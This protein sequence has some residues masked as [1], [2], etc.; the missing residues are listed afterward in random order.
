MAI[1]LKKRIIAA[2]LIPV[3]VL[4]ITLC[5]VKQTKAV[6]GAVIGAVGVL[7]DVIIGVEQSDTYAQWYEN[8]YRPK[9]NEMLKDA[10]KAVGLPSNWD[11]VADFI[12]TTYGGD[13]LQNLLIWMRE[14]GKI[15]ENETKTDDE[16]KQILYQMYDNSSVNSNNDTVTISN[17]LRDYILFLTEAYQQNNKMY[18]GY[19]LDLRYYDIGYR[20]NFIQNEVVPNQDDYLYFIC[21]DNQNSYILK[22]SKS[23]YSF[24][25]G[26]GSA[27]PIYSTYLYN[28]LTFNAL[29]QS[30][31][32]FKI[33]NDG[34]YS[35]VSNQYISQSAQTSFLLMRENYSY[36][37]SDYNPFSN[38][39]N[40]APNLRNSTLIS[41]GKVYSYYIYSNIA[42]FQDGQRGR[43]PYY[44]DNSSYQDFS[45]TTGDYTFGSNNTNYTTYEDITNYNDSF[46]TTNGDYPTP[47]DVSDFINNNNINIMNGGSGGG[48]G[49]TSG[50]GS[51][52]VVNNNNPVF[53]NNIRIGFDIPSMSGNSVSGNGSGESG[54]I[55][56]I[57]GFLSQIG[58]VIGDLIK[59]IGQVLADIV[60]GIA[61]VV[62]DLLESIPT[63]FGDFMGALIGWLPQE[64]QALITLSITAMIIVGLIKLFRG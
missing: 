61:S 29:Y 15:G 8:Y 45:Q 55:G 53:N 48:N 50:N 40:Q 58:H 54:G 14:T 20:S 38:L 27:T 49:G 18:T 9:Y 7:A 59:N 41:Y 6:V 56:S 34:T 4:N 3:L 26:T 2:I 42:L 30:G 39:G 43:N 44:V 1:S 22:I 37:I 10:F 62:S 25:L 63:V 57:F 23:E 32:V 28:N 64:L 31:V 47:T 5:N 60:E 11:R 46:N 12:S 51:V 21:C 35:E 19:S 13:P 16:L 17:D 24:V 36:R 52:S 33:L